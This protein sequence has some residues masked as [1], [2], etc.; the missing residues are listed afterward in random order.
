MRHKGRL[1]HHSPL[2]MTAVLKST[3]IRWCGPVALL[4]PQPWPG[5]P[6]TIAAPEGPLKML[7]SNRSSLTNCRVLNTFMFHTIKSLCYKSNITNVCNRICQCSNLS[8]SKSVYLARM[9]HTKCLHCVL[10][11][12]P[13]IAK[14]RSKIEKYFTA[15][16]VLQST[17]VCWNNNNIEIRFKY[18]HSQKNTISQKKNYHG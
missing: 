1:K 7:L 10:S 3:C 13:G 4:L 15:S 17:I 2:S 18:V 8:F 6:D 11:Y 14:Q 16:S 5:E 12:G 9:S